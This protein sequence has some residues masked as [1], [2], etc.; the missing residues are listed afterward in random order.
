LVLTVLLAV[1]LA[2][3]QALASQKDPLIVTHIT[4]IVQRTASLISIGIN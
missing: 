4:T 2:A 3:A 1:T